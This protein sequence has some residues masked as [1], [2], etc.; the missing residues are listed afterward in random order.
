[1]ISWACLVAAILAYG[2]GSLLQAKGA[3][4]GPAGMSLV[5]AAGEFLRSWQYMLGTAL[6][7]AAVALSGVALRTL[8]LFVVQ[9]ASASSL[10]ITAIGSTYLFPRERQR[11]TLPA[12]V[13]VVAGL[14]LLG[15]AAAP[16]RS[17][18]IG[19]TGALL[20]GLGLPVLMAASVVLTRLEVSH[21][22]REAALAGLAYAGMG[23]SLRT[24]HVPGN[25]WLTA[26]QPA[27]LAA[28]GYL[29]VALF[30]F[31]RALRSGTVTEAM[32]IV[33]SIDT[34]LP[35]GIGLLLLG[36]ATRPGWGPAMLAGL[37]LT[38]AGLTTLIHRI[39]ED[40]AEPAPELTAAASHPV[41][42]QTFS[43]R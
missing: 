21:H 10:V 17:V 37:A 33:V 41:S 14:V 4:R 7:I 11:G 2:G 16:G 25:P 29:V 43:G 23:I 34:I 9:A 13:A 15:S 31:G 32:A 5:R 42:R 28:V 3:R 8:P 6:D 18:T 26:V 35:A 39:S 20:L 19:P 27:A 30:Y 22:V 36:D 38:V 40:P 1:V 24:L 12:I